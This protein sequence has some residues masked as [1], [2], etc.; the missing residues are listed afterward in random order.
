MSLMYHCTFHV[1]VLT[2][3]AAHWKV[4]FLRGEMLVLMVD[5]TRTW[6]SERRLPKESLRTE[7]KKTT[8][9]Y[10]LCQY[11]LIFICLWLSVFVFLRPSICVCLLPTLAKCKTVLILFFSKTSM[12]GKLPGNGKLLKKNKI[13]RHIT[14]LYCTEPC[15]TKLVNLVVFYPLVPTIDPVM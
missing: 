14:R 6:I 3:G 9:W 12:G 15:S 7:R 8:K 4:K 5:T 11:K 2:F 10:Y 1:D 13:K